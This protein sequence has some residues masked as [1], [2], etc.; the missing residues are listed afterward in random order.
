MNVKKVFTLLLLAFVAVSVLLA[1]R[2]IGPESTGNSSP[3][4]TA[5]ADG[6]VTAVGLETK[7]VESQYSVVYFHAAHRCTTCRN[8]ENFSHE[9]LTP[10]IE[11]GGIA[12][13][14]ADYTSDA[15][16]ALVKQFK[17][18]ASTVVL[19][20]VQDGK[21]IR[22]KNLEEVWNHTNNQSDFTA[23]IH[24]AWSEFKTS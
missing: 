21:V 9:A 2:K 6:S 12:W 3:S 13:Q 10:E 17:V 1:L 18:Y 19:V 5:G 24:Q 22:W 14:T 16:S 23:F 11:A 7:L 4:A 15:N 20:E 8:I